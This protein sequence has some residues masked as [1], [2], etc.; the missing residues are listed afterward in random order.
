MSA[1][2]HYRQKSSL[3]KTF[4]GKEGRQGHCQ[5]S[6]WWCAACAGYKGAA[7]IGL[8]DLLQEGSF[9]WSD[10]S[11]VAYT[12]WN[13]REPNNMN[14]EDCVAMFPVSKQLSFA[15]LVVRST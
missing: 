5:C 1:G 3:V 7:W 9:A 15:M 11:V 8:N 14:N 10:T 13:T 12:H 2:L 6:K 4:A